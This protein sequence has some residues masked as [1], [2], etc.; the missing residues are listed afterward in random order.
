MPS[1]EAGGRA[2]PIWNGL[3][4]WCWRRR[5]AAYS[6]ARSG[7]FMAICETKACIAAAASGFGRSGDPGGRRLDALAR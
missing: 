5:A 4:G 1:A 2:L 3:V 7:A 6:E